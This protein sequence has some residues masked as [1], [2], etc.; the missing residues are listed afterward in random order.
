MIRS[1]Q[2]IAA[3]CIL[4]MGATALAADCNLSVPSPY[5]FGSYD[6]INNLDIAIDYTVSCS[7]TVGTIETVNVVVAFSPG[8]G[9][10]AARTMSNG[11]NTLN[12]NLYKDAARTQV[13]GDGTGGT[14][15]GTA[16]FVLTNSQPTQSAAGT[17]FG[18][19]FGGQNVSAGTYVTTTP[20]TVTMT[21]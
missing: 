1:V 10:Y 18:R 2:C 14:V 13:R 19:I 3:A 11:T 16:T 12:Y 21:F 7:R 9:T 5:N 20:I 6:T 15:T 4:S 17:I 8:S